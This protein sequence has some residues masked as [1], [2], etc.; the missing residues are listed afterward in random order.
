MSFR[1]QD[2][3]NNFVDHLHKALAQ[4]GIHVF[5]DNEMLRRGNLISHELL[6]AIEELRFGVVVFP[7][8][9]ADSCWCLDELAKIKDF[10][11]SRG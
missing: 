1:G 8:N 9:Y 6:K 3:R 11:D 2:T 5:K 4:N 10:Q 7:K